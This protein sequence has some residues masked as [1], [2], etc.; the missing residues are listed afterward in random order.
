LTDLSDQLSH[1]RMT[2][3][4]LRKLGYTVSRIKLFKVSPC[5]DFYPLILGLFLFNFVSSF[6]TLKKC[7]RTNK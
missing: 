2:S 6:N 7:H 5:G 1:Q 4:L 3:D